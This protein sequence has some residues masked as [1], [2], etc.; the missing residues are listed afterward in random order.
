MSPLR[1]LLLV[2]VCLGCDGAVRRA[3]A[4]SCQERVVARTLSADRQLEAVAY[5]RECRASAGVPPVVAVGIGER[6][7][8][9]P[10]VAYPQ[11]GILVD[12]SGVDLR[13][14]KGQLTVCGIGALVVG[15]GAAPEQRSDVVFTCD[16]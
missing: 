5:R 13:W 14:K 16:Q 15:P 10:P 8:N 11:W 3:M 12:P 4:P 2:A 1:P 9:F 7:D 6:I